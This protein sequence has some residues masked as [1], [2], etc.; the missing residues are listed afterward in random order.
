VEINASAEDRLSLQD[1]AA[2]C[3]TYRATLEAAYAQ[4]LNEV[5][6]AAVLLDAMVEIAKTHG[7]HSDVDQAVSILQ[8]GGQFTVKST[9][10]GRITVWQN[11]DCQP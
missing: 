2:L 4:R 7:Y 8:V 9:P 11:A 10:A 3:N 1:A 6:G 5:G